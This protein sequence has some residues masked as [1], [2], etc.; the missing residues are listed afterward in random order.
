LDDVP[1]TIR[2]DSEVWEAMKAEAEP[3]EDTPN[4]VL[5]RKFG[6]AAP[7]AGDPPAEKPAPPSPLRP[8][9]AR[10]SSNGKPIRRT[11]APRG[12]LLPEEA[13]ELPIL[14]VLDERGGRAAAS[15]AIEAVGA[16]VDDKLT[17]LDRDELATGGLRWQKRVQ[18]TRLRLAERGLLQKDSPRGVWEITDDGR[19]ALTA[20][21]TRV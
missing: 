3:L 20:Q 15:E 14:R 19:R 10:Q 7:R 6:L 1:I 12:S 18:F 16:L 8:R 9:A 5:R 13:Y 17:Q 11:R 21:S 4:T 2:V